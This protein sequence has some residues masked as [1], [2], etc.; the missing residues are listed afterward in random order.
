MRSDQSDA[1]I[2]ASAAT[3][4]NSFARELNAEESFSEDESLLLESWLKSSAHDDDAWAEKLLG[5]R[6]SN[7]E[8]EGKR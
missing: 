4:G 3:A 7:E 5:G 2:G 1:G 8:P 6:E